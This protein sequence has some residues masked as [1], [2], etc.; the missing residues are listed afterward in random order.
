MA[1]WLGPSVSFVNLG[2]GSVRR[3]SLVDLP[4][5]IEGPEGPYLLAS[6]AGGVSK[7]DVDRGLS[8][9]AFRTTGGRDAI[10]RLGLLWLVDGRPRHGVKDQGESSLLRAYD[11][12][13]GVEVGKVK[14]P[15]NVNRL[16]ATDV[17]LWARGRDT[18]VEVRIDGDTRVAGVW[19]APSKQTWVAV[20]PL[21]R[22]GLSIPIGLGGEVTRLTCRALDE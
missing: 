1:N 11:L 6:R 7:L 15:A 10:V 2:D 16:C 4:R 20:D 12:A 22:L 8:T 19:A 14:L 17:G 9:E 5:V 18:L 3:R 13:D 21:R